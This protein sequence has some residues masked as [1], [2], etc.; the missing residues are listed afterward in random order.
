MT[1]TASQLMAGLG[2]KLVSRAT[3]GV[4]WESA[5]FMRM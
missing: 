5:G 2:A 4:V 3:V 1:P